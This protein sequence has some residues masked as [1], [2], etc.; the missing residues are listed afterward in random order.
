MSRRATR[1]DRGLA[2]GGKTR[3]LTVAAS[4]LILLSR[5]RKQA[6]DSGFCHRLLVS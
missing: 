4:H 6:V 3:S 5:A 2:A 1:R